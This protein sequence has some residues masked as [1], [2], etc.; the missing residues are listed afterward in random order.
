MF[1]K[2][3]VAVDGTKESLRAVREA[4][5]IA[6]DHH[7]DSV[8]IVTVIPVLVYSDADY[9]PVREHGEQH[10]SMVLPAVELLN[11]ASVRSEVAMLHGRP[12]DEIV[13]Y[14]NEVGV[15]LLVIGTRAMGRSR[16]VAVGGS[17]SRKT[18]R[19]AQC[20]VLLVG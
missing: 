4:C 9:D 10:M 12:A 6:V 16:S 5:S 1:K 15:D 2:I 7:S 11:E 8:C 19:Q 18:I 13:R 3:A 17:V 14:A 20:P